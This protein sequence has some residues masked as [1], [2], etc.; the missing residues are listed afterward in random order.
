MFTF[1]SRDQGWCDD[2]NAGA[3]SWFEASLAR[4]PRTD[5]DDQ[6][7]CNGAAEWTGSYEWTGEWMK[8]HEQSLESQPR[9][10]IQ[11]NEIAST[12]V[13]DYSI[14]LTN[15]HELVQHVSEG[16]RV[17]LWACACFGGWENRVYEANITVLGVDDLTDG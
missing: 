6:G 12:E 9:H 14:E 13:K 15:E 3:W 4:L 11:R 1:R 5:E 8:L 17:I 2:R 7:P 16:D 10:T